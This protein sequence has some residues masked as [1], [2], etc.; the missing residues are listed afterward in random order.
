MASR[1]SSPGS[2]SRA[3]RTTAQKSRSQPDQ[4]KARARGGELRSTP[5]EKPAGR[6]ASTGGRA[7]KSALQDHANSRSSNAGGGR[8]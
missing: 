4:Q 1:T 8:K 2:G 5:A 6:S 7:G 3:G